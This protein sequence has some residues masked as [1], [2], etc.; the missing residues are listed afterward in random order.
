MSL[1]PSRVR[2]YAPLLLVFAAARIAQA[3]VP[4]QLP[5]LGESGTM[6]RHPGKVIWA[7]LVTPDLAVAE[8]FYGGLFG[9]TFKHVHAGRT[10]YAVALLG[11][12]PVGGLVQRTIPTG[13]HRQPAWLTFIA[14]RDVDA[15]RRIAMS[16]GAKSVSEPKTYAGRG[17]QAVLADPDGAVFA[18]LA[19]QGG[20]P[21]D[22][23]AAPG[24]WIWSSL[25]THEPGKSAA[26]YQALFGYDVFDVPSDDAG[27][28]DPAE[29]VILSSDDYARAGINPLPGG[30]G[31]RHPHWLN[32]VRVASAPDAAAKAVALGGRVLVDPHRDRHGDMTALL[33]DPTGAPVGVMEWSNTESKAEPK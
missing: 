29:H 6:E 4:L 28:H 27:E 13:E 5:P 20:D 25:L 14:V 9:W 26:F 30:A 12:R 3:A 32:F 16:H 19:S 33:A 10:D 22:Y 11:D 24:E 17:R 1:F 23:L 15:A 7:D 18:I 2:L 8:R 31:R 21:P